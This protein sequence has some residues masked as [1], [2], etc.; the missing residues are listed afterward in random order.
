MKIFWVIALLCA[1][2]EPGLRFQV[3]F[4]EAGGLKPGD[5]VT[6]RGLSVGQVLDVDLAPDGVLAKLEVRAR[7]R[8]HMDSAAQFRVEGEKLV[9][10]KMMLV[11][12]PGKPPGRLLKE[13]EQVKGEKNRSGPIKEA[14]EALQKSVE[15]ARSQAQG[16]GR[17]VLHPDR[18]PPRNMGA[19]VDLDHPG[20]HRLRLIGVKVLESTADG[21]SWDGFGAGGPDLLLQ[22]WAGNQQ[23]L[24]T[25]RLDDRHEH[26]WDELLSSP[27]DL[28]ERPILKIKVL[29]MDAT[30]SDEI[31]IIEFQPGKQDVKTGRLFRLAAGRI[32]E[33]QLKVERVEFSKGKK[34]PTKEEK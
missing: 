17:A 31:G 13:G 14:Q 19:T 11:V 24:L 34:Q 16:L 9:T 5:N 32:S 18:L 8:K 29:D 33:L 27:F 21:A 23:I 12:E 7:F 1:C 10:G 6:V 3:Y 4:Q 20:Q 25:E 15:H 2:E 28:K 30:F 22:A 26:S